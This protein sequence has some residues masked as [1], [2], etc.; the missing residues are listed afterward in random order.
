M[1][2]GGTFIAYKSAGIQDELK[3][4]RKAVRLIQPDTAVF[5]DEPGRLKEKG[6]TA[7]IM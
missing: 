3:S 4:A 6:E 1:K 2:K 5:L 7:K